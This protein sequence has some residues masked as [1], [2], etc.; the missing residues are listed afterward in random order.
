MA[1]ALPISRECSRYSD[2]EQR[3]K[4]IYLANR[5]RLEPSDTEAWKRGE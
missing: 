4:A 5:W 1:T 2:K 3:V